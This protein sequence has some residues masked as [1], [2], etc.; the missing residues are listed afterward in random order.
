MIADGERD[1]SRA[2]RWAALLLVAAVLLIYGQTR[3]HAFLTFDDGSYV[4]ENPHVRSGLS[5]A[6]ARWAFLEFHS[7][8]WH[9][10]TWLSHQLDCQLFDLDAGPHHLVN[11]ALHAVNACLCFAFLRRATGATWSSLLVAFLFAVHP[12]RVESVAWAS[13]RK[14]V[15]SGTFFFLTLLA[16]ERHARAPSGGRYALVVAAFALGLMAKPMLLTLPAILVLLDL[17]PLERQSVRT[18]ALEKLPL[19]AL[20]LA[21]A[22]ITLQ[23]QAAGGALRSVEVLPFGARVATALLGTLAYLRQAFWPLDLAFFYPHPAFVAPAEFSPTAPAV[24]AAGAGL[25]AI[26]TAA[27]LLRRRAP[28]LL[29][30]W[31]WTLVMLVPVIGLVQVGAQSHA[32]RYAYLP[33]VGFTIAVV[34]GLRQLVTGAVARRALF[35]A[36]CAAGIALAAIAHRQVATWRDMR[37]LCQRALAVTRRNYVAHEHLALLLQKE[38]DLDQ[39]EE[40]YRATLEIAP[41]LYDAHSNLGA[42]YMQR[43]DVQRAEACYREALRLQPDFLDARLNWGLLAERE[44]DLAGARVHYEQAEREHPDD[45]RPALKVGDAAFSLGD[46][47]GARAAYA[48]ALELDSGS[49]DAH[50][51]LAHVLAESGDLAAALREL[52]ASEQAEASGSRAR[53]VHAW[54]LAAAADPALRDPERARALLA[55]C[56]ASGEAPQWLHQRAEAAVLAALGRY[57]DAVRAAAEAAARAPRGFWETLKAE[58]LLYESGR[59]LER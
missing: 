37:S 45:A 49:A 56:A 23:A 2:P 17:W 59:P 3:G 33:L 5:L 55:E 42:L 31:T 36:G 25:A 8:N 24:I 19:L 14:D 48:R 26:S 54:V 20:S 21:S 22:W 47:A 27:L 53:H 39:A 38:G 41:R 28:A 1:R 46:L 18:L 52:T 40:Q 44:G 34:F 16:Y 10:L 58:R 9:P 12:Q 13:E 50:A 30:G 29:V 35:G 57:P 51:G 11:A 43:G 15:L 32:D 6:N 7:A 4:T